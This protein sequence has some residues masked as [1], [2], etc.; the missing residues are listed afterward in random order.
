MP[1]DYQ[2]PLSGRP[3]Q[4]QSPM[5]TLGRLYELQSAQAEAEAR[6]MAL[7]QQRQA[8]KDREAMGAA[9]SV[10]LLTRENAIEAVKKAG[11]PHLVPTVNEQFDKWDKAAGE[12]R[13]LRNEAADAERGYL[14]GLAADVKAHGYDP[15]SAL[16]AIDHAIRELG[17]DDPAVSERLQGKRQEI[18]SAGQDPKAIEAI[19]NG[20]LAAD[21]KNAAR[22]TA[23]ASAARAATAEKDAAIARPGK[24]A[25]VRGQQRAEAAAAL[26]A[27]QNQSDYNRMRD[28]LP[29]WLSRLFP[30]K[31][32]R[33]RVRQVGLTPE[34]ATTDAD[35][36]AAR[37]ESIRHNMATEAQAT[38]SL[39]ETIAEHGRL[40][41]RAG[42]GAD[43]RLTANG[44]AVAERWRADALLDIRKAKDNNDLSDA[45]YKER[46]DIVERAYK[47]ALEQGGKKPASTPPPPPPPPEKSRSLGN[48]MPNVP[49]AGPVAAPAPVTEALKGAKPGTYVLTDNSTWRVL[50]DGSIIRVNR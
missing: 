47:S 32:D 31:M 39:K 21:P 8:Q 3:A 16:A 24:E 10:P 12:R 18:I 20:M 11:S 30:D 48:L 6:Q 50:K 45:E 29:A 35:R 22:V 36:D 25:Q 13:K 26:S 43:G 42:L 2:I 15:M 38:A 27:A 5:Q 33:E 9:F 40:Q 41:Q 46:V 49:A 19:V 34:Q 7:Q 14:G 44:I 37:R 1:I 17:Q 28:D 23:E 4:V